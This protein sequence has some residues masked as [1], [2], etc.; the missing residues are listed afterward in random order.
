[1]LCSVEL[2]VQYWTWHG[3]YYSVI[4]LKK[5]ATVIR[6]KFSCLQDNYCSTL[7]CIPT[8]DIDVWVY[9]WAH[10]CANVCIQVSCKLCLSRVEQGMCRQIM[11][12][13]DRTKHSIL[14]D[15]MY[16]EFSMLRFKKTMTVEIRHLAKVTWVVSGKIPFLL[17]CLPLK[18]QKH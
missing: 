3:R 12:F 4:R 8:M 16:I 9:T 2:I 6:V 11:N 10:E 1:M 7:F 13:K 17:V 15:Y 14:L 18:L 5:Y